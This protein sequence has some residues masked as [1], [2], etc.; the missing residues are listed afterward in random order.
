V[1]VFLFLFSF[2]FLW[3]HAFDDSVALTM[4]K[5]F[6]C[7]I[8][9]RFGVF[10]F[11]LLQFLATGLVAGICWY[12]L[13]RRSSRISSGTLDVE[14]LCS[15]MLTGQTINGTDFGNFND[16]ARIG[17]GVVAGVF[18]LL[19]LISLFGYV[20]FSLLTSP[21]LTSRIQGLLVPLPE[22]GAW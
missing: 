15:V 18:S 17:E 2:S 4:S 22:T 1:L 5:H 20:Y 13:H 21:I 16:S 7:C 6:C 10:V 3:F 8:P 19:A 11:S 12:A 14:C 9:V